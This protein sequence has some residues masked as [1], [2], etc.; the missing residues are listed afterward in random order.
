MDL[1]EV[2]GAEFQTWS[3]EIFTDLDASRGEED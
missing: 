1:A 3:K 2:L